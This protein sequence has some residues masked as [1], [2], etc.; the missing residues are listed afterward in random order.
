MVFALLGRQIDIHTGGI[1]HIPVH[2]NNELAQAEAVSG[3]RYVKYWLHNEFITVEGK[4]IGK[5]LG[6]MIYLYQ[7]IER[8]FPALALRYFYLTGHYRSPMNF[9]WEALEGA[10]ATLNRLYRHFFEELN[11]ASG[12]SMD[13]KFAE[14]F[15]TA[16]GNDL[17]TPSAVAH[18]WDLIK[19]TSVSPA[20]KKASLLWADQ[21]LG[22]G[23]MGARPSAKLSV[24]K[25]ELPEE[26][27]ALMEEREAARAE[28][29][30]T[31]ADEL[32]AAIEAAGYEIKD[33]A[34]GPRLSKK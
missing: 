20:D 5:S 4:R 33:T 16:I 29:N 28:K 27:R 30:F 14:D 13:K 8:G 24:Q 10:S 15:R 21:A 32:R 17:G 3:K 6:N 31:K 34:E 7:V 18:V 25:D 11:G 23:L 9:T 12:G 22:L 1:D 26:V 19:N 2:H